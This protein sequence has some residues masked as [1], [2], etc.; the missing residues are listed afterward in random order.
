[1]TDQPY[2]HAMDKMRTEFLP[3]E[4]CVLSKDTL[5][6]GTKT[7]CCWLD[8]KNIGHLIACL[9]R[10]QQELHERQLP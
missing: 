3:I 7:A 2:Q 1:M 8:H 6:L 4:S 9:L 10:I 5:I